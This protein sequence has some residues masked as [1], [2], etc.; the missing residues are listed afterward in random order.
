MPISKNEF[1]L[2]DSIVYLNHGAFGA[3][4][5]EV[6]EKQQYWQKRLERQPSKMISRDLAD[7]LAE[8]RLA[9]SAY[10][11]CEK[12]DLVYIPSPT[13][14][15]NVVAHSLKLAKGDE[16][17]TSNHEYGACLNTWEFYSK[18]RGFKIVEQKIRWPISSQEQILEDFWQG[19][20]NKTKL[21]FISHICSA[22]ALTMPVEQIIKR[23]GE[24]GIMVFVDGAHA[25]SQ[26]D[27]N[28]SELGADF[29]VGACHKW[30]C[31]PKGS[32][33]LYVKP[34]KQ[35]L[36]EPLVVSWAWG[37]HQRM[38]FGSSLLN[39]NQYPGTRDFSAYLSVK[40]AIEY[41]KRNNWAALRAEAMELV[42][43]T[44]DKADKIDGLSKVYPKNRGLYQQM[45]L[46]ELTQD[47]DVIKTKEIL[48]NDYKIELPVHS[49]NGHNFLRFSIQAYNNHKDTEKFI[50]A[51]SEM[52]SYD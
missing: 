25:P 42:D 19:V 17:L 24:A 11:Q 26:L 8:A 28:L 13:Y 45:G 3:T 49:W 32:S 4:P 48:Y 39:S 46:L 44:L 21:I 10:L 34:E 23:A 52:F 2:D 40:S 47:A 7:L 6:F 20:T 43:D 5:K 29:Y 37:S 9:L 35:E 51:L 30:L 50:L 27:L 38:D 16:V 12:D 18:K 22:T 1:L 15:V 14:G 41:Q 31:A 33:F 36:I